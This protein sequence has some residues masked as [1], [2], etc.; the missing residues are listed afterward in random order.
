MTNAELLGDGKE[1]WFAAYTD[2][3][4]WECGPFPT[5]EIAAMEFMRQE[6]LVIGDLFAV[7]RMV[8]HTPDIPVDS[9]LE[10]LVSDVR[11]TEYW[12]SEWLNGI[13]QDEKDKLKLLLD[14]A[15]IAWLE[16]I[17]RTPSFGLIEDI[18][19]CM[20]GGDTV[21]FFDE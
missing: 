8:K 16:Q 12:A 20:A 10:W 13:D 3:A 17:G 11:L 14:L 18:Q 6:S 2:A 1:L 21:V 5:K 9:V 19:D 7:G 15:V 4:E